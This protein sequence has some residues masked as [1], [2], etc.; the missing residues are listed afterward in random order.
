[1]FAFRRLFRASS[2]DSFGEWKAK[3]LLLLVDVSFIAN[4]GLAI[5]PNALG[6]LRPWFFGLLVAAP[7]GIGN[8]V[9]FSNRR[10]WAAYS[11][12]FAS[13]SRTKRGTADAA[14]ALVVIVA[15]VLPFVLRSLTTDLAW[16]E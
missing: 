8:E 6:S 13:L 14:V 15:F 5:F 12:R 9:I 10:R 3:M 4:I 2:E 1:M 16:W 7:V 11:K